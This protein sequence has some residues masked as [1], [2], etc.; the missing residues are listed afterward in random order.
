M[1]SESQILALMLYI[2]V[3]CSA[4]ML[5]ESLQSNV[6][7]D[8]AASVRA[9]A[10]KREARWLWSARKG[11]GKVGSWDGGH[12]ELAGSSVRDRN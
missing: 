11:Y 5:T 9:A 12:W 7:G 3:S 8:A 10:D 2:C 4:V 6:S 1:Q